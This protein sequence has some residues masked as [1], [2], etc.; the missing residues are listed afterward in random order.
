MS[1]NAFDQ[2]LSVKKWN[3]LPMWSHVLLEVFFNKNYHKLFHPFML[4]IH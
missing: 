2:N 1:V 3:M 4:P